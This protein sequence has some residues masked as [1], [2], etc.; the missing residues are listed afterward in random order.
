L[1]RDRIGVLIASSFFAIAYSPQLT[2][3]TFCQ[4]SFAKMFKSSLL[5]L[6]IAAI[7]SARSSLGEHARVINARKLT[8]E[9]TYDFIVT[10]GGI[11]GLTIADRLTENPHGL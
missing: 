3:S 5:T 4:P 1:E 7:G 9:T 6:S 2:F 8:N 10:G 11:A